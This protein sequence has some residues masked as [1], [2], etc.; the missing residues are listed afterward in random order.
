MS[1]LGASDKEK[2]ILQLSNKDVGI[3]F[4]IMDK[5]FVKPS[6]VDIELIKLASKNNINSDVHLMVENPIDDLYI[7]K[8]IEYGANCIIIHY[9]I[10]QFEKALRYLLI[11]KNE[12]NKYKKDFKIGI[13]LNPDTD[14][15]VLDKYIDLIDKVLV[16]SVEPGYGGQEY[17][18]KT[19][20]KINDLKKKY[21]NLTIEVD[22]G[23]NLKIIRSDIAKLIDDFVVGSL[24]TNS[25]N[26]D[27]IIKKIKEELI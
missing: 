2:I 3:H 7:D 26:I 17:I 10:E 22:G 27:E 4:D 16:M 25:N 20:S 5:K 8:A 1:I 21:P 13:A 15:K 6:G 14:I 18:T 11:K 19:D 23:I 24:I 9:E 12:M